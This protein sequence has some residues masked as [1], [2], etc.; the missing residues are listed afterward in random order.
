[1]SEAHHSHDIGPKARDGVIY[2]YCYNCRVCNCDDPDK[3]LEKEC[4]PN[5]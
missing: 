3:K 1:M 2:L 5:G 4:D